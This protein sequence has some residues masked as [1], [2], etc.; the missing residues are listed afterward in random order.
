MLSVHKILTGDHPLLS[1][2]IPVISAVPNRCLPEGPEQ[3]DGHCPPCGY[4]DA[5][6]ASMGA[7]E[8]DGDGVGV[9]G[10][11][12]RGFS[13]GIGVGVG[14]GS[15]VALGVGEASGD[16][17]GVGVGVGSAVATT[18]GDGEGDGD[19]VGA[20]V[21]FGV[22]DGVGTTTTGSGVSCVGEAVGAA[23]C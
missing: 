9:A 8:L 4:G 6:G 1:T 22:E 3:Q 11:V 14:V 21:A 7:R 12:R 17:E 10:G 18:V 19:A 20:T 15:A 13:V 23:V 5:V 2:S 16:S